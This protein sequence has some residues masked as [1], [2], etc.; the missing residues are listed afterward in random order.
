MALDPNEIHY[1]IRGQ[2]YGPIGLH[3]FVDRIR[4]GQ[5]TPQDYVWDEDLDDWI[6]IERYAALMASLGEDLPDDIDPSDPRLLA[7]ESSMIDAE[8]ESP[9]A[10][11]FLRLAAFIIDDLV[12]I[13]PMAIWTKIYQDLTGSD[14]ITLQ[15]LLEASGPELDTMLDQLTL[16]TGG[17]FLVR[18]VYHALLESSPWQAT[19]GKL[20]LGLRVTDVHGA[21]ISLGRAAARHFAR[22]LCQMTFFFGYVMIM[23]TARNQGLHDKVAG[24]LVVRHRR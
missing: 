5:V 16:L 22:L 13:I 8:L 15:M 1:G 20:V 7:L 9:P 23:L 11:F 3:T 14:P 19:V 21:R 2:K 12:L 18:G 10:G 17:A 4:A 24:T 6:A